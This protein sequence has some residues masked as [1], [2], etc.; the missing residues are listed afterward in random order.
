V[1]MRRAWIFTGDTFRFR[2]A[3]HKSADFPAST[4]AR[5]RSCS[6]SVQALTNGNIN[7]PQSATKP[8]DVIVGTE[9]RQGVNRQPLFV[10]LTIGLQPF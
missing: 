9:E 3:A 5:S 10:L 8:F 7:L 6:S 1:P 4:I 2:A